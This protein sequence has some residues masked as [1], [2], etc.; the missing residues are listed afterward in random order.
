ML[1][2]ACLA[3]AC[4]LGAWLARLA[5]FMLFTQIPAAPRRLFALSLGLFTLSLAW[6]GLVFGHSP[7]PIPASDG[8]LGLPLREEEAENLPNNR[9]LRRERDDAHR[10]SLLERR[11]HEVEEDGSDVMEEL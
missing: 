6:L 1:A 11:F 8:Y 2:G 7:T 10:E 3:G 5:C 9:T 4:L